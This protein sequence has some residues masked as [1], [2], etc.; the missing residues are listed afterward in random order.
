MEEGMTQSYQLESLFLLTSD[1][2]G[3]MVTL[4]SSD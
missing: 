3:S 2:L 1:Q 4:E